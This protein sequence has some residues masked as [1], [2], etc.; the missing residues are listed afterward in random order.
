MGL[1]REIAHVRGGNLCYTGMRGATHGGSCLRLLLVQW[2]TVSRLGQRRAAKWAFPGKKQDYELP[3]C[4]AL[5][6]SIVQG[7]QNHWE[8]QLIDDMVAEVF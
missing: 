7:I 4:E 5:L 8:V 2:L 1:L 3:K 6:Q